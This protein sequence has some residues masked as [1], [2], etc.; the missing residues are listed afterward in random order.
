MISGKHI[1]RICIAVIVLALVVTL[2]FMNGIGITSVAKG[3][4]YEDRLFSTDMVHKIDIVMDDWESFISTCENEE[5][6]ACTVIIDGEKYSN[7]GIRAKGNTSLSSVKSMN[8]ERYSFKLEFDQYE[9]GK[10]YHGLDKLCLNNLIQDNTM[11]KD[12]LV[13]QMMYEF[14]VDTPLC[15]YVYITVNGEDWGLYLAVEGV[16]DSFLERNYDSEGELYKPDSM[17]FGAGRGNGKDFDMGDFD[18]GESDDKK[19]EDT[20]KKEAASTERSKDKRNDRGGMPEGFDG[21]F[22]GGMPEGFDGGNFPGGGM[23]G[24]FGGFGMGNDDVKLKYSD[25]NFS[26][27]SN[28]FNNAKTDIS[29]SDKKRLINSLKNLTEYTDLENTVDIDEVLR[30]FVVHIFVCNGDSY[31]GQM[32]HNYYLHEEDGQ[33]SMIPWDYNL[34]YGTFMGGNATSTVNESID[35]PI[36]NGSVDD[37]PMLGWIFSD[38]TYTDQYHELFEEFIEEWFDSGKL[39]QMI[40]DTTELIRPYVEKDPTKFCTTEEFEKGLV[41]I[42][43]FVLLRAEAVSNQLNGDNTSVDC[44]DLNTSDMGTMS[45]GR[46]GFGGMGGRDFPGGKR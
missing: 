3:I 6:S 10:T 21:D 2:I 13:Y 45:A 43:Q 26:S 5:Y 20:D 25:D 23:Q 39:E 1:D 4:G 11:M 40:E 17:S 36:S 41:A 14:G 15:S 16:E 35:K 42:K 37:R 34:A 44:S 38:E 19:S 18:F 28:I 46:G 31:T 8:S 22:L 12:Y 24:G 32:I 27:Y 30:Y 29:K 33:L 9:K 7:T